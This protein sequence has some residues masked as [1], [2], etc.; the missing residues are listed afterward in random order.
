MMVL[1]IAGFFQASQQTA[2]SKNLPRTASKRSLMGLKSIKKI[3]PLQCLSLFSG[4]GGLDRGLEQAGAME[5]PWAVEWSQKAIHSY[6]ANLTDPD[7]TQLYLGS[8]NEYLLRGL[9]GSFSRLIA[10]LGLV[11]LIVAG[12]PCKGFSRAQQAKDSFK[13]KGYASL[14]ASLLAFINLYC[15]S[16]AILE[17]VFDMCVSLTKEKKENIFS[18][19]ICF[20]VAM[21]YQVQV[22][23]MDA[24]TYGS[25]Q[26]R[27]RL[28]ISIAAPGYKPIFSP[29]QTHTHPRDISRRKIGVTQSGEKFGFRRFE[30]CPFSFVSAKQSTRDLA[31]IDDGRIATCVPFPDHRVGLRFHV[32]KRSPIMKNVPRY[33]KC[34]GWASALKQDLMPKAIVHRVLE[35]KG[36]SVEWIA[37]NSKAFK[38]M[39][40]DR[41]WPSV[42]TSID[43]DDSRHGQCVHWEEHRVPTL[44]EARRA[45]SI[46]D[47]EVLIGSSA[48][49]WEVVGNGVD[50]KNAVALGISLREAWLSSDTQ[51]LLAIQ[52]AVYFSTSERYGL[53][54]QQKQEEEEETRDEEESIQST[55][56]DELAPSPQLAQHSEQHKDRSQAHDN[57]DSASLNFEPPIEPISIARAKSPPIP[58]ITIPSTSS[59]N[60]SSR[61][62]SPTPASHVDRLPPLTMLPTP[63]ADKHVKSEQLVSR[64]RRF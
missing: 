38:R 54:F 39:D 11:D 17:N 63:P 10:T 36:R 15:P 19:I 41:L 30:Y 35:G 32:Y 33:P 20:L 47:D 29:P 62:D 18:Q 27:S 34:Q 58:L 45:Q 13:A 9:G 5:C 1:E 3:V 16:Y 59:S 25:S 64:P 46:P 24:W 12:S 48:D 37:P 40:P 28:F 2:Q 57:E 60:A 56:E 43:A 52:R 14:I 44:L 49:K 8:V 21:G 53:N 4:W 31:Y 26:M 55:D 50:R 6:R 7:K 22:F 61:N 51:N 23:N 42:R